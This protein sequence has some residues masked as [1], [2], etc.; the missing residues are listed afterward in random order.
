MMKKPFGRL[1]ENHLG[2]DSVHKS[3]LHPGCVELPLC[4][5]DLEPHG[6]KMARLLLSQIPFIAFFFFSFVFK[7]FLV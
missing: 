7:C 5:A 2:C 6:H 3:L 4:E 1:L